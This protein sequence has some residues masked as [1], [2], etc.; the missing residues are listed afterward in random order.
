[1]CTVGDLIL[2]GEGHKDWLSSIKFH[3]RGALLGTTSGD[4]TFKIWFL[5][6]Y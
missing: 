4:G 3:P 1:M 5:F 2:S 6:I